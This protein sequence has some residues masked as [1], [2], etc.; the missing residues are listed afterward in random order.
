MLVAGLLGFF[1]W[2]LFAGGV[3]LRLLPHLLLFFNDL[4]FV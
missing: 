3:S 1:V 2:F 4:V